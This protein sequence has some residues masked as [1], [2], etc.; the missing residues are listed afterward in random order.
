MMSHFMVTAVRTYI[1]NETQVRNFMIRKE[2][3]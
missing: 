2:E 3:L 1:L